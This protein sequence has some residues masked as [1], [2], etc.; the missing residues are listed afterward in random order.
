MWKSIW[1]SIRGLLASKK[2]MMAV[3][4]AVVWLVGKVG[5]DLDVEDLAGAV[6][7][8]WV[9]IFGQGVADHGK[10]ALEAQ[11]EISRAATES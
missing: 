7:S 3:L 4:S 11:A 2:A 6:G 1:K 10:G 8:L 5:F 9:Y